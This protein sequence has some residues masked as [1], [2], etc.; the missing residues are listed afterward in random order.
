MRAKLHG[1]VAL[2]SLFLVTFASLIMQHKV[3]EQATQHKVREKSFDERAQHCY[4]NFT[5]PPSYNLSNFVNY[6]QQARV[7]VAD[8][9]TYNKLQA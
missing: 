7:I 8:N 5:Q 2:L 3:G 9:S 1:K 4:I 6:A